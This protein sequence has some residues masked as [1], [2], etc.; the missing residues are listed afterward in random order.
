[1]FLIFSLGISFTPKEIGE[2]LVS[3]KK[4]G[5][6]VPN[7]PFRIMVGESEI[8]DASK[9]KVYGEGCEKAVAG[10][11]AEFRVDTRKAGMALTI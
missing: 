11:T 6:H 1:M 3:V 5:R 9:V 8:A 4:R 7:S 2:H 10:E